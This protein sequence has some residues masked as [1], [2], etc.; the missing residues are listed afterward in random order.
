MSW[1]KTVQK[2]LNCTVTDLQTVVDGS[3]W[4]GLCEG[5]C[6]LLPVVLCTCSCAIRTQQQW[7]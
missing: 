3:S 7:R 1:M 2:D 4:R 6:K 5:C